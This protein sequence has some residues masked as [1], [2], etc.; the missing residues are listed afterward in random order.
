MEVDITEFRVYLNFEQVGTN[1]IMTHVPWFSVLS[2][3]EWAVM[4]D[5]RHQLYVWANFWFQNIKVKE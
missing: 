5:S 3:E 4:V 1:S 2:E